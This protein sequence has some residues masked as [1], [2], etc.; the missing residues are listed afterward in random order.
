LEQLL[1]LHAP[2]V[3]GKL[4][5]ALKMFHWIVIMKKQSQHTS[6]EAMLRMSK[7]KCFKACPWLSSVA[8]AADKT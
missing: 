3:D 2:D 5:A 1:S 8:R 7:G 6:K 4:I